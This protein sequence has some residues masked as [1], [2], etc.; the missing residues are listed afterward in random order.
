MHV[1]RDIDQIR[2]NGIADEVA[3][4][5]R[6]ILQQLLAKI[7]AKGVGHEV[8]KVGKGFAENDVSV[9]RNPFLQFLLEIATTMLILAQAGNF[10]HEVLE[11]S[12]GKAID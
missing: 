1:Q 2:G 8:S 6:R 7:I 9:V 4:F 11:S 3:L 10:T 5:I 12:T